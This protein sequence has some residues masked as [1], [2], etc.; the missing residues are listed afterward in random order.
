M[1][2]SSF[3]TFYSVQI[4]YLV[5]DLIKKIIIVCAFEP[6]NILVCII[7]KHKSCERAKTLLF[8]IITKY[9]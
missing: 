2:S 5:F 7:S 6:T 4:I 8:P 3:L 1:I 9:K